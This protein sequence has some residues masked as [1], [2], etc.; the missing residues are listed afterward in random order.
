M[1][2]MCNVMDYGAT[3]YAR[4]NWQGGMPWTDGSD[5]LLRHLEAFINGEDVDSESGLPH[6]DHV[7]CNAIFLAEW[8]RTHKELDNRASYKN[9]TKEDEQPNAKECA[10]NSLC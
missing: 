8:F 7:L 2:G 5:C 3:K 4:A 6:I 1:R 9:N 10:N